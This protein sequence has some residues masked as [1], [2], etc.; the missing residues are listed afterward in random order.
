MSDPARWQINQYAPPSL[1]PLFDPAQPQQ[2]P[3]QQQSQQLRPLQPSP[4]RGYSTY[5][6]PNIQLPEPDKA[7]N[8]RTRISRAC[9]ACRRKKIKC[10][11]SGPGNTCKNC[12]SSKL[13]CT[14]NDR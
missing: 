7:D 3:Q 5:T 6:K 2:Q 9:D 14:F 12:K 8:R 4:F 11:T 1:T 10:D 13:D